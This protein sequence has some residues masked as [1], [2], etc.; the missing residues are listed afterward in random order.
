[1]SAFAAS[2][3]SVYSPVRKRGVENINNVFKPHRGAPFGYAP[4]EGTERRDAAWLFDSFQ[5]PRFHVG[6]QTERRD[7]AGSVPLI[8]PTASLTSLYRVAA[9]GEDLKK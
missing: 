5:S 2:R 9:D 8:D 7:A 1:M 3:C 4:E 6:L